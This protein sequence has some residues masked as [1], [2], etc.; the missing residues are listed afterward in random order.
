[1]YHLDNASGVPEMPEPKDTQSISPRWFGESQEQGGISWPGADWFNVVQAELLNL[2]AAAGIEPEKHAY[3]QLS[4]AIPVLGDARVRKDIAERSG[5][6]MIGSP[7]IIAELSEVVAS[8]MARVKTNGAITPFDGGM[9]DWVFDPSDLSNEV[10]KYPRLFIAPQSDLTGKSGA[11]RLNVG[12]KI[13]SVK[14]GV[15][16]TD[17]FALNAEIL[18]QLVK[19]NNGKREILL[20]PEIFITSIDCGAVDPNF[21]G[22]AG[23]RAGSSYGGRAGTCF[24]TQDSVSLADVIRVAGTPT[25]RVTGLHLRNISVVS[26]DF[27]NG[28]RTEFGSRS[29]RTAFRF[30]YCGGNVVLANLYAV[31]F[32]KAYSENEVWDGVKY[33]IRG[34]YCSNADGTVPAFELGSKSS[35]NS[36]NLKIDHLHIEFSPYSME[37]GFCEHVTFDNLKIE[38]HRKMDATHYVVQI[39]SESTKINISNSMFVTNPSTL[40]YFMNDQGRYTKLI[41]N[42]FSGGTPN[43]KDK[44]PGVRWYYG[45]NFTNLYDKTI[46]GCSFDNC[47]P[48]AATDG[49]N[50][51]PIVTGH[52]TKFSGRVS[53]AASGT[54]YDENNV[55]T[56]QS[57]ISTNS[58]MVSVGFGCNIEDLFYN[59]NGSATK[60]AGPLVYFRG[61]KS[62]FSNVRYREGDTQPYRLTGGSG[63]NIVEPMGTYWSNTAGGVIYCQGKQSINITA[64]TNVVQLNGMAGQMVVLSAQVTGCV[65]KH[66]ASFL[67]LKGGADVSMTVGTKYLFVLETASKAVQIA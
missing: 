55:D 14:Y 11:W 9:A 44:Y 61:N 54:I 12:E 48:S 28:D 32:E 59:F 42:W 39:L 4:K 37:L 21:V 58:G 6:L 7:E 29:K 19:W 30:E 16:L 33:N 26:L 65:L 1:M 25:S 57:F 22:S 53:A 2:L 10:S 43:K 34:L 35:D 64:A 56:G 49:G 38:S 27:F 18:T 46:D 23:A 41:N 20:P 52:Y 3:D 60:L 8:A 36:N 45:L 31:G 15:G 51:Y 67:V 47:L 17:D 40:Q 62:K 5:Q 24:I 50:D 13:E 66:D 63:D